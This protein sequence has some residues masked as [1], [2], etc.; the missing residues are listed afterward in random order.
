MKGD[1]PSVPGQDGGAPTTA[2]TPR[3][4]VLVLSGYGVRV[5]VERGHLA[6]SDGRGKERRQGRFS[7]ADRSLRRVVVL[8]HTG[9]VT[10]EALRWLRDVRC[11]FAQIDADGEVITA[12]GPDGLDDA[13][14]RRAQALAPYSGVGP[15][16]ARDLL[17]RKLAGQAAVLDR[18]LPESAAEAA[19]YIRGLI[20]ALEAAEEREGLMLI[21]ADAANVYWEG[22]AGVAV[23]W[24]TK[25]AASVPDHWTAFGSRLSPLS[26]RSQR[27]ADPVNAL[28]N[29]A[30]AI[31]E[32]ETRIALL[33]VG[34]DPGM[35]VLHADQ[36]AR[37]SLALDAMEP[38]RADMDDW[39]LGQLATR[40]FSRRDF[41]E[42]RDGQARLMA[43]F[44]KVVGELVGP[45]AASR[46][47]PVAERIA[48]AMMDAAPNGERTAM[49]TPLTK[50]NR[51]ESRPAARGGK[52]PQPAVAASLPAAC[53]ECGVVLPR[54]GQSYCPECIP[55][56]S[57]VL[58][59]LGMARLAQMRSEGRDPAHG[60]EAGRLRAEKR[61][62]RAAANREWQREHGGDQTDPES[63]RR[64]ILPKLAG[65]SQRAMME[66]TGLGRAWC[67]RIRLGRAVPHRRHWDA[68]RA[69]AEVEGDNN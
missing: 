6:V 40:T 62:E 11:S 1:T 49:P 23:R 52:R 47:A 16:I 42:T 63:F 28:L 50:A 44:A 35:G 30:Y 56:P 57:E 34:L 45:L 61:T 39:V 68:L 7:R 60:G 13:R 12:F 20:R 24:A 4:G 46:I 65:V 29:Y 58:G 48:R 3:N 5:A 14:L 67:Q 31:L 18:W 10:F 51:I 8:G 54:R 9:A 36:R 38:V 55:N 41:W 69:L 33:A 53:R 66:R 64:E 21:E 15:V 26:G 22:W 25:D 43:P 19:R 2:A 37:D 32:A 17:R 59:R 27:A